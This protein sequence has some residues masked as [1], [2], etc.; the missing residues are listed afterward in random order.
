MSRLLEDLVTDEER[1][2]IERILASVEMRFDKLVAL[3]GLDPSNDFTHSDL[4]ALNFC[5][6]DLRGFDFTGSDL[7]DTAIDGNTKIDDTTILTDSSVR[8]TEKED[9]PIVQLMMSVASASSTPARRSLLAEIETRFGKSSHVIQFVVN[10]AAETD[11]LETFLD[12]LD[13]LPAQMSITH[14]RKLA[15]NGERVLKRKM[16]KSRSR[17][18][19]QTTTIFASSRI[20]ERLQNSE[21]S[22]AS[23]WLARIAVVADKQARTHTL[24]GTVEPT[25]EVLITSLKELPKAASDAK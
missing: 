19:R 16:A 1:S 21:D 11:D 18:R 12:F 3:A 23:V 9:I 17:T 14:M 7:R 6:A 4:R 15:Q 22:L 5:G 25:E 10:A 24:N 20:V 8:W 13:F 2:A